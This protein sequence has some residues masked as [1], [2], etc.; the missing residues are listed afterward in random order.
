ML[1]TCLEC[2]PLAEHALPKYW[3]SELIEMNNYTLIKDSAEEGIEF[4]FSSF[5]EARLKSAEAEEKRVQDSIS[6]K[7]MVNNITTILLQNIIQLISF[8][9]PLFEDVQAAVYLKD[10]KFPE[11]LSQTA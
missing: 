8:V 11:M 7:N 10:Q 6:L 2:G 3:Q 5:Y 4:H 9:S 1:L